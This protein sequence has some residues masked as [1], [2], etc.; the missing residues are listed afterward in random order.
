MDVRWLFFIAAVP[1]VGFLTWVFVNF[2]RDR[3]KK[4]ERDAGIYPHRR[5]KGGLWE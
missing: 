1:A 3:N 5:D 2:S 4:R